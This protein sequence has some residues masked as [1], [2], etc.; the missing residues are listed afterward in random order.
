MQSFPKLNARYWIALCAASVLG[1]NTGD[2]LAEEMHIGHIE[3]LVPLA[4]LLVVI[5]LAAKRRPATA[6]FLFWAAIITVRTAATNVGDAFHEFGIGFPI[7]LPI[8]T[9][10]LAV[11]VW[12]YRAGR[13]LN[14]G[15]EPPPFN[16]LYWVCIMM[17]GIW[18][19]LIG[20][21]MSFGAHLGPL[22]AS[23]VLGAMAATMLF[24]F[25][26]AT[27]LAPFAYW[28][29]IA[30]IRAA[31]TAAG[32]FLA[33]ALGLGV[34]TTITGMSF[35]LLIASFYGTEQG[36]TSNGRPVA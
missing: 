20:D 19:T 18:G 11:T 8:S 23:V 12:A 5:F 24:G 31:G 3:G 9:I 26:P 17:A 7:S 30:M 28:S 2:Y 25:K 1:T 13:P 32:D 36:K 21:F 15:S 34:S 14:T 22:V 27:L 4:L 16:T 10:I 35:A 6:I 33:H 29:T